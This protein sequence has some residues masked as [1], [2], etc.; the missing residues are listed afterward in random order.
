MIALF[1]ITV[2]QFGER[3]RGLEMLRTEGLFTE[4][5]GALKGLHSLLPG[6]RY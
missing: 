3:V 6:V 5:G 4:L 2:P 1:M